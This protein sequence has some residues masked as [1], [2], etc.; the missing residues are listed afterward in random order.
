MIYTIF[1][2]LM[3]KLYGENIWTG[4]VPQPV[5]SEAVQGWNGYHPSLARL[6]S[7]PGRKIVVD[8]GVW[9]GQSTITM[10]DAMRRNGIDGAVIAVDTFLGSPEHWRA[11]MFGLKHS[12]P[13]LQQMFMSNVVAAG[14][15][16]YVI[17]IAQT[18][19]T[20]CSI[21]ARLDIRPTIIHVDAAHEYREVLRDVEDY[22]E[23]LDESGYLIGDDYHM[24]WPGV[25]QAAG[26]FSARVRKP[27]LIEVPKFILHKA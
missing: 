8:V 13:A 10:A 4:F 27:L 1:A 16:D 2:E 26:E 6:T 20:A 15:T 3:D 5:E 24:S 9:K 17:P 22:W 7:S 12:I 11:G 25:I 19:T 18:S 21:L 23:I 14:L